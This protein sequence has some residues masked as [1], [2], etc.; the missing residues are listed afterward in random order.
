MRE[1]WGL[2]PIYNSKQR[3]IPGELRIKKVS[4]QGV[5]K[6]AICLARSEQNIYRE[7]WEV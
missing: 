4:W 7:Y 6:Q 1:K 5:R 3:L 2:P